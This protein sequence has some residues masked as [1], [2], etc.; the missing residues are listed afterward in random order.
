[1]VLWEIVQKEFQC[2]MKRKEAMPSEYSMRGISLLHLQ[3]SLLL[4]FLQLN[5]EQRLF[6]DLTRFSARLD[7][8]SV[9]LFLRGAFRLA[10]DFLII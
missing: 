6:L 7:T 3:V 5:M 8:S 1:M 2:Q 9:S 10:Q 4:L